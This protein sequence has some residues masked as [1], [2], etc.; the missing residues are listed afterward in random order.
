MS[1]KGAV[2]G[3]AFCFSPVTMRLVRRLGLLIG[4]LSADSPRAYAE[5][6]PFPAAAGM[7]GQV[8]FIPEIFGSKSLRADNS[9][10]QP[11]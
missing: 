1:G 6:R 4:A 9:Q 7:P 3:A 10:L 8:P 5:F 11:W 2:K